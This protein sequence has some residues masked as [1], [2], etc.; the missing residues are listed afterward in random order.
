MLEA[1]KSALPAWPCKAAGLRA[2]GQPQHTML[3]WRP[4]GFSFIFSLCASLLPSVKC[5]EVC[6]WEK[7]SA[8]MTVFLFWVDTAL[9]SSTRSLPVLKQ[10]YR[11]RVQR[12]HVSAPRPAA[13]G[14]GR[15]RARTRSLAG[16]GWGTSQQL[17]CL[18]RAGSDVALRA[19]VPSPTS[20][21][22]TSPSLPLA[23][24][25]DP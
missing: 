25:P 5:F 11:Y 15:A 1:A 9:E 10:A 12:V 16:S 13:A 8:G 19:S 14:L 18:S 3:C 20:L 24:S 7:P 2:D 17:S 21:P 23:L 22:A 6:G 4:G